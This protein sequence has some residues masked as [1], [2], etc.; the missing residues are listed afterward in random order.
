MSLFE[1]MKKEKIRKKSEDFIKKCS[2]LTDKEIEQEFLDNKEFEDNE[3]VLS[4]LFFH[5]PDLIRILPIEFQK[6]RVNSNL[7]MFSKAS[8]EAKKVIVASWLSDNKFFMNAPLVG[9]EGEEY[10]SYLRLYFKSPDDVAKLYMEDLK[11]V[12][13]ILAL[14]DLKETEMLLDKI[15]DKLTDR[16]WEYIIPVNSVFIKYASQ[17]IQTKYAEDDK[18][19]LHIN[20]DARRNFIRKQVDK[21]KADTTLLATMP[22]DVQVEFL[23]MYPYMLNYVSDQVLV[24]VLKYDISL[25]RYVNI[26]YHKNKEDK[27]QEILYGILE[28]ISNKSNEELINIL[29]D[30]CVLPAKGKVYRFDKKSNNLSYQYTKRM[31][32]IIQSLSVEQMVTLINIDVNYVL[33][34]IVPVYNENSDIETKES[35]IID[36]NSRCLNLFECYYGQTVYE[37]YYRVINKIYNEFLANIDAYDFQ[38]DY[39]T[40]FDLFK[41][42][43]NRKI[44]L[45]NDNDKISIYVGMNLLYKGKS[46]DNSRKV[47]VKLLNDLLTNA[48]GKEI[49]NNL[50]IYN[51]YS[52]EI[53][54]SRLNFIP[55]DL[56]LNFCS[57]NFTNLSTLLFIVKSDKTRE[58]FKFY[59]NIMINI[60]HENKETLF[61]AVENFTYYKEILMDIRDKSLS[62]E[63]LENLIDLFASFGNEY[64]ITKREELSSYEIKVLKEL[65]KN[66]SVVK[67]DRICRNLL[68]SYLF[69]KGYDENGNYGWLEVSTIKQLCDIFEIENLRNI[70]IDGQNV[71]N[72][73]EISMFTFIKFLFERKDMDTYLALIENIVV[74]KVRRNIVAVTE[75]FNKIKKYRVEIINDQIV[76]LQDIEMLLI[77]AP[78]YGKKIEKDGVTVYTIKDQDFKVLASYTDDGV[79]YNC[80][81]VSELTKNSYGYDK[82]IKDGS[83]R[84]S[85]FEND[86]LVKMNKDRKSAN[87]MKVSFIIAIGKLS[88][89]LLNIAKEHDIPVVYIEG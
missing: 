56:L 55:F 11:T 22:F 81:N 82:L 52:L 29:V 86:T 18:Y 15:K 35:I 34:Y 78:E 77:E 13:T 51:L 5:H 36:C 42:L 44:V 31:I 74:N 76:S 38:K 58:L 41:I 2:K 89:E 69:N 27:S 67:D 17:A 62:D 39:D 71:F 9:L 23:L 75:L 28:N 47:A 30:K 88:N 83:I 1:R 33:P 61:K 8:D 57:Y 12:I 40:I 68:S 43:F 80:I 54:D 14:G 21:V 20:G 37:D 24:D 65:V 84:F 53:F 45:N 16:Q 26:P 85:T 60:Y 19:T 64:N 3:I 50:E 63:E 73:D 70:V 59:Y 4:Y 32:K 49:N 87:S 79:H 25:I 66:V 48:Y 72:E 7:N 10:N 6:S 46:T